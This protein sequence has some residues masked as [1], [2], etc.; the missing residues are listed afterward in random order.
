MNRPLPKASAWSAPFW[1][2]AR[3]GNL[4][5]QECTDCCEKIMYPKRFCPKCLGE[6]LHFIPAKGTGTIYTLTTQMAGPPSGFEAL[7]PYVIAVIQ[8]D[9]GVQMMSNIVGPSATE[10]RIGDRVAVEFASIEGTE[11][12]LPVFHLTGGAA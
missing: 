10:A 2:S 9:E 5:I 3:E 11:T 1:Q 7:L 8:L 6:H 4:V 12:V